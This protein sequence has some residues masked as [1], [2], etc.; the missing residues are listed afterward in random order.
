MV[1]VASPIICLK[2]ELLYCTRYRW[3]RLYIFTTT[4]TVERAIARL[5]G[6][7]G[8]NEDGVPLPNVI[9]DHLMEKKALSSGIAFYLANAMVVTGKDPQQIAEEVSSDMLDLTALP[10]QS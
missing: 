9:I 5:L 7:D 3:R 1:M 6:I 10:I 4:V 2:F 8:V